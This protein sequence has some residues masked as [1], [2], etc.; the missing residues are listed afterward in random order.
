MSIDVAAILDKFPEITKE[1]FDRSFPLVDPGVRPFG[2]RVL[3]QIRNAKTKTA[4][5]LILVEE[6]KK[7]DQWNTQVALLRSIGPLAFR[8]RNSGEAWPEG[9]WA[10][11]GDFVRV[12]RWGGDRFSVLISGDAPEKE[13]ALFCMFL[14]HELSGEVTSNPL[15]L[16]NTIL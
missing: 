11:P 8:N 4:G 2:T 13:Y 3:V 9:A 10:S 15:A 5:G 1:E 6:T 12:P 7:D 14:D 16:I